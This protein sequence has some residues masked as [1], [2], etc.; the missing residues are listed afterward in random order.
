MT[1]ALDAG[2]GTGLFACMEDIPLCICSIFCFGWICAKT[3]AKAPGHDCSVCHCFNPMAPW[4]HRKFLG[5]KP[6]DFGQD[7]V[8]CLVSSFCCPC[9][10]CQ[11]GRQA[12]VEPFKFD[13]L[14]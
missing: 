9:A 8:D 2:Y 13:C 6:G 11:N 4:Y 1:D 12:K 10:T 5:K 3:S 14:E 7:C